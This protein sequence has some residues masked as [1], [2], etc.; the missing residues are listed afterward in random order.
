[1]GLLTMGRE[2]WLKTV[3]DVHLAS[4]PL[5]ID[6]E[7]E[8]ELH[9]YWWVDEL[10]KGLRLGA[11]C[12]LILH[13]AKPL[14]PSTDV[15]KFCLD[16]IGRQQSP[17]LEGRQYAMLCLARVVSKIF[18]NLFSMLKFRGLQEI[19]HISRSLLEISMLVPLAHFSFQSQSLGVWKTLFL[20]DWI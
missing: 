2:Y 19:V 18:W 6:W 9:R 11:G 10:Q 20:L 14:F 1:M 17:D 13:A 12:T 7:T 16:N 5:L 15:L 8:M 3:L 4:S